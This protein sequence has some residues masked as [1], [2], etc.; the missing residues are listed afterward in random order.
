MDGWLSHDAK[1]L[2]PTRIGYPVSDDDGLQQWG[3]LVQC[4]H[5]VYTANWRVVAYSAWISERVGIL[6]A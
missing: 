4:S 5:H 3:T 2:A 1:A 6:V